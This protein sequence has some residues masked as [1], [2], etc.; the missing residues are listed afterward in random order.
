MVH[1]GRFR[2]AGTIAEIVPVD[3]KARKKTLIAPL[4]YD[5]VKLPFADGQFDLVYSFDVLH[6]CP[7][8]WHL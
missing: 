2:Q 5:G 7:D 3:V 1:H 8:P 6:H 4:L